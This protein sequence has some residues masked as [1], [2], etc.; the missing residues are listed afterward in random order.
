MRILVAI[1]GSNDATAA[2]AWV[3]RL[4]L[5]A[6]RSVRLFT[7]VLPPIAFVD[8]DSAHETRDALVAQAQRLVNDTAAELCLGGDVT[9]GEVVVENDAREAI[10]AAARESGANLIVMGARGLLLTTM[11]RAPRASGYCQAAPSWPRSKQSAAPRSK[12]SCPR[13][14]SGSVRGSP[15]PKW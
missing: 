2:V 8:I 3:R 13:R 1:D 14:R 9:T 6:D 15:R 11:R 7:A 10:V 5:P 12:R 4:P